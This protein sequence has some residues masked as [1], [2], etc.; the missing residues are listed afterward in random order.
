LQEPALKGFYDRSDARLVSAA[1]AREQQRVVSSVFYGYSAQILSKWCCVSLHT[2]LSWKAGES[3]PSAPALRLFELRA[4]LRLSAIHGSGRS[5]APP[6][7]TAATGP[8]ADLELCY[9]PWFNRQL[10]MVCSS[11][12]TARDAAEARN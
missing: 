4:A 3:S 5:G 10:S 2:A 12:R 1:Q 9:C 11:T 8:K 6:Q 7:R